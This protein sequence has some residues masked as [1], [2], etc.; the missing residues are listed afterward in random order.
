VVNR[1]PL[2]ATSQSVFGEP[3]PLMAADD[4]LGMAWFLARALGTSGQ[5]VIE[6][7]D[8]KTD[9]LLGSIMVS[10][11]TDTPVKLIR[12]GTNG[13]AFLTNGPQ[14]PQQGDGVYL[15]SGAFVTTPSVQARTTLTFEH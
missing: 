12:W 2:N 8:L 7:F 1:F 14:G 15:I 11:V 9:A 10:G 6:T 5:Y 13:L 4:T 3:T